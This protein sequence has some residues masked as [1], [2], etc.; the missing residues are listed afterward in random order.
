[1]TATKWLADR[2][3]MPILAAAWMLA[4]RWGKDNLAYAL[5]VP[6]LFLVW[7]MFMHWQGRPPHPGTAGHKRQI[8]AIRNWHALDAF[9]LLMLM[10]FEGAVALMAEGETVS[11]AAWS[12]VFAFL[13]A[14]YVLVSFCSRIFLVRAKRLARPE[15]G[16]AP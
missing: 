13:F 9:S 8:N 1:M 16:G 14:P 3:V 7:R 2:I 5:V 11:A 15:E 6:M 12:G 4:T 10:F